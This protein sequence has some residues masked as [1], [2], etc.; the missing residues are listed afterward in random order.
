MKPAYLLPLILAI[1]LQPLIAFCASE[2][3]AHALTPEQIQKVAR[4]VTSKITI[5]VG[6]KPSSISGSGVIIKKSGNNYTLVTNAHVVCV[7]GSSS[8]C[9]KHEGFSITTPDQKIHSV[10]S[11]AVKNLPTLDLS[12]IQFQSNQDYA[13]ASSGD[14]D[15]LKVDDPIYASGFPKIKN[16]F[17]FNHGTITA[18]VKNRIKGDEGGY[19]IFYDASTNKG[20]SGGGIFNSKGELIAIHGRG[21]LLS[22]TSL[23]HKK[24][25]QLDDVLG[26][27]PFPFDKLII[28]QKITGI[29]RGVPIKY[30]QDKSSSPILKSDK[31]A[32]SADGWFVIALNKL[33]N[34]DGKENTDTNEKEA[35]QACSEAIKLN[36]NYLMAYYIRG[37]LWQQLDM[38][39]NATKDYKKVAQL[40]PTSMRTYIASSDAKLRLG[41]LD[42]RASNS[43]VENTYINEALDDAN[44]AISL[45]PTYPFSYLMRA[46]SYQQI[47]KISLA[48]NDLNRAIE[49]D[50]NNFLFRFARASLYMQSEKP[51]LAISDFDYIVESDKLDDSLL[52]F[53]A[54]ARLTWSDKKGAIADIK[55]AINL[56]EDNSQNTIIYHSFLNSL[57]NN[58]TNNSG[59]VS[60]F[61][62]LDMVPPNSVKFYLIRA[63]K[64]QFEKD[65]QG[66][67]ADYNRAIKIKP[68]AQSF[69]SRAF[70]KQQDIKDYQGAEKDYTY[71]INFQPR[72]LI[73]TLYLYRGTL[74]FYYLH[75]K[76][77]AITDLQEAARICKQKFS[78]TECLVYTHTLSLM[79]QKT[80]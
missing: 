60:Y 72:E 15:Q 33:M 51:S 19:T 80:P 44:K 25:T 37:Q 13:V 3:T 2:S 54:Y 53:R 9:K 1:V 75:N 17:S 36:P 6:G 79:V 71:A 64:K 24:R 5:E 57:D 38:M 67:L 28:G 32:T 46:N 52:F 48:I 70:L 11:T 29:N 23:L 27:I 30:L 74:R 8:N 47:R 35:V 78:D 59:A 73:M 65:F 16:G 49:I 63:T 41:R 10:K 45:D 77:G 18:N 61:K 62:L 39:D 12:I 7:K 31:N 50:S 40:Q 43:G 55:Q 69:M 66:A 68:S 56:A 4:S 21:D 14:S 34:N 42:Y 26:A 76:Q 20:M 58:Q 22:N